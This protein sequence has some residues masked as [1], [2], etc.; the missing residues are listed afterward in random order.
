VAVKSGLSVDMLSRKRRLANGVN[1]RG[2]FIR[3]SRKGD[4]S[5]FKA[6]SYEVEKVS[7]GIKSFV[8]KL[9]GHFGRAK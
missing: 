4:K 9:R 5:N 3:E 7:L 6:S 8:E 2:Q 1:A